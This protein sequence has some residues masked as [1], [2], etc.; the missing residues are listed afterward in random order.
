MRDE[1]SV[2]RPVRE[3]T[4]SVHPE[5]SIGDE[6]RRGRRCQFERDVEVDDDFLI[7]CRTDP[8]TSR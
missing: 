3:D 5:R 8:D 4:R 1:V 7:L 6:H 2:D